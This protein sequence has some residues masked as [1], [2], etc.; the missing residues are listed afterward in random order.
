VNPVS[1]CGDLMKAF[2]YQ[3][4]PAVDQI[5]WYGRSS[6]I[7]KVISSAANNYDRPIVATEC[8]G[9]T[10]KFTVNNL[11]KEAMDQ[12]AKGINLMEPHAVW[13]TD[14]V[15]IQ[16]DLSPA[17]AKFG[18][19][20][21]A[22]NEYIGRLQGMLQG[23]SHVADIGILYPIASLQGAYHF[24]PGDP[25]MGGVIPGEADYLDIGEILSLDARSDFTY[26]HPEILDEKCI[27]QGGKIRMNN[28][29]NPE[30]YQVMIIPGSKTIQLSNLVKI[31]SFYD[32][33]GV[34]IATSAL[35]VHSSEAGGDGEV[36]RL[37][38]SMF[39]ENCYDKPGVAL[40]SASS[41]WNT[42]GFMPANA[43]DGRLE[44]AWKPSQGNFRGE[45][46]E[47]SFGNA[48][49]VSQVRLRGTGNLDFGFS[50]SC[51]NG[52]R[53]IECGKWE[54]AGEDKSVSFEPVTTEA[55]RIVLTTGEPDKVTVPEIEVL[56]PQNSNIVSLLKSRTVNTNGRGG[57][58]YFISLPAAAMLK[59]VLDE[60][61]IA[62]DTRFEQ[63]LAVTGGNLTYLHKRLNGRNIWF[64]ANSSGNE[65]DVP[66]SLKGNFKLE[67]WNP[68]SGQ[69]TPLAT[70]TTADKK[71]VVTSGRLILSTEESVFWVEK[72]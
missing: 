30:E 66:V 10:G 20:L 44:T 41:C 51:R 39:G 25:G 47:L 65:I 69:I 42:A 58:A 49:Q 3:D 28:R 40:L 46:L 21:P 48:R 9:A 13:Y 70:T 19:A 61:G 6:F 4:I 18:A 43:V 55:I 33:G 26:I 29:L 60:A 7:Y 35:P 1:I 14:A 68:H 45:S 54:G 8:Y 64:F 23:G 11:Y 32:Q 52:D 34:V 24:G 67:K 22:F 17:S 71:D 16:P 72:Q 53:W 50:V 36:Q 38:K 57:K 2:K 5:F 12:F 56:D 31:N 27:V 59:A 63:S 37:I 62:W 15:D